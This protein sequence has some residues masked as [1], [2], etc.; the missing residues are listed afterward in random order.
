MQVFCKTFFLPFNNDEV[1]SILSGEYI[2]P[3]ELS[4]LLLN[5]GKPL[6]DYCLKGMIGC[7]LTC[8]KLVKGHL[9]QEMG[10]L[11]GC[12]CF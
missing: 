9:G 3:A 4:P 7:M 5:I 12:L 6:T 10:M 8:F 1:E 2:L 11:S